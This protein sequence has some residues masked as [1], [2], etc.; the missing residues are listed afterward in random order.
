MA[1]G[2]PNKDFL[3]KWLREHNKT[4]RERTEIYRK[5]SMRYFQINLTVASALIT[6]LTFFISFF[7]NPKNLGILNFFIIIIIGTSI[8]L[9]VVFGSII[10]EFFEKKTDFGDFNS[11]TISFH[12]GNVPKNNKPDELEEFYKTFIS[13]FIVNDK[14]FIN[15]EEILIEDDIRNLFVLHYYASNYQRIAKKFRKLLELE[16]MIILGSIIVQLTYSLFFVIGIN[17]FLIVII[18]FIIGAYVVLNSIAKITLVGV[19]ASLNRIKKRNTKILTLLKTLL[20]RFG[21]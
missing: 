8:S 5:S 17:P 9:I 2:N 12:K 6:T 16:V 11:R 15:N 13:K 18:C 1:S 21:V 10:Y 7:N 4:A 20:N 19:Y 3:I 14:R